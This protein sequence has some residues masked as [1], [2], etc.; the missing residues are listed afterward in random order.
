MTQGSDSSDSSDDFVD[1]SGELP[2]PSCF[3]VPGSSGVP[4]QFLDQHELG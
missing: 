3:V 1:C 4:A 2:S